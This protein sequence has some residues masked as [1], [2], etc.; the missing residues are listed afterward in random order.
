MPTRG[1]LIDL[2]RF[3]EI[4]EYCAV[5]AKPR[6]AQNLFAPEL[7]TSRDGP[8]K[9]VLFTSPLPDTFRLGDYDNSKP[10]SPNTEAI[11][12]LPCPGTQVQSSNTLPEVGMG[13]EWPVGLDGFSEEELA[14]L[15][16][17]FFDEGHRNGGTDY[18]EQWWN[19]GN[20]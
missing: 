15:A 1:M 7:H 2:G 3:W 10:D 17:N 13:A 11:S 12:A 14:A 19:S 5:S 16:N 4:L 6:A 18:E 20:L 9:E 8:K